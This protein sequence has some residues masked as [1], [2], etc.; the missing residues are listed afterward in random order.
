MSLEEEMSAMAKEN[1][2]VESQ[3]NRIKVDML[4]SAPV[5]PTAP[6]PGPGQQNTEEKENELKRKN[7]KISSYYEN[8]RTNVFSLLGEFIGKFEEGMV[9]FSKV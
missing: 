1:S 2:K 3:I 5:P 9:S 4:P 7:A 6:V 8:L